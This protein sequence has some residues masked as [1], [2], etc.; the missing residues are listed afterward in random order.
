[1]IVASPFQLGALRFKNRIFIPAH[2]TGL[3]DAQGKGTDHAFDYYTLRLRGGAGLVF[4]GET[5]VQKNGESWGIPISQVANRDFYTGLH[6]IAQQNNC[7]L[8][9]QISHQGG[10]VWWEPGVQALA[11]SSIPQPI[12]GVRPDSL[13]R[14]DIADLRKSFVLATSLTKEC[15]L[16]GCELKADQGKLIYQFLSRRYNRRADEFGGSMKNRARFLIEILSEIRART[17]PFCIGL[18]MSS[19]SW[20]APDDTFPDISVSETRE[21]LQYLW[22]E[23]LIDYV[24]LSAATNV[25][26]K[27]YWDGHLDLTHEHASIV[28]IVQGIRN[29]FDMPVLY[30]GQFRPV[31]EANVAVERGVCDM[32]GFARAHIADPEFSNKELGFNI[33]PTRPC[34]RCNQGCVGNTWEGRGVTCVVNPTST[35]SETTQL[36]FTRAVRPSLLVIGGGPAGMECALRAADAGFRVILADDKGQLGGRLKLAAEQ[37]KNVDWARLLMYY[38]E[39]I[40]RSPYIEVRV[41]CKV[42]D[43]EALGTF[44]EV[45]FAGGRHPLDLMEYSIDRIPFVLHV[46][47]S[48]SRILEFR[49]QSVVVVDEDPFQGTLVFAEQAARIGA[50]VTVITTHEFVGKGLD[51]VSLAARIAGLRSAGVCLRPFTEIACLSKG[52]IAFRCVCS[53]AYEDGF[54]DVVVLGTTPLKAVIPDTISKTTNVR[55]I[56]DAHFP[57]GVEFALRDAVSA[58]NH[59][60]KKYLNENS[61][62]NF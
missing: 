53:G 28:E 6:E 24:N 42:S 17:S 52:K 23:K 31:S 47:D 5:L 1:M 20:Y 43:P 54:V 36:P 15:M 62:T 46:D 45:V 29:S 10:Q 39:R 22:E 33:E 9:D 59:L 51:Q 37:L 40:A 57:R 32:V 3:F 44:D 21:V 55:V 61:N 41:N 2:A 18:R 49:D 50:K 12:S 19:D 35:F 8:F 60:V 38:E 16:D 26:P 4:L 14:K 11:P 48:W 13:G 25:W 27:G 56:G 7:K 58:V 34:I 30:A